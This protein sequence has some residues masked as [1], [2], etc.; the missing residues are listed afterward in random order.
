MIISQ[1]GEGKM[2]MEHNNPPNKKEERKL[3][4]PFWCILLI[5]ILVSL[6]SISGTNTIQK[7]LNNTEVN[8]RIYCENKATGVLCDN[9]VKCNI[10]ISHYPNGSIL[11]ANVSAT[12]KTNGVWN[13]SFGN[14]TTIGIY[15]I[16]GTCI[17]MGLKDSG[18]TNFEVVSAL[19]TSSTSGLAA[20]LSLLAVPGIMVFFGINFRKRHLPLA[21][22]FS[23]AAFWFILLG[24]NTASGIAGNQTN[25]SGI[26]PNI[27]TLYIMFIWIM[28][29]FAGYFIGYFIYVFGKGLTKQ[30]KDEFEIE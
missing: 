4:C 16:A 2:K 11:A 15:D 3:F 23:I 24:I 29:A 10:T 25:A 21:L 19:D 5:G 22:L 17:G 6:P 14:L 28:I 1:Y 30:E 9:S 8:Y 13:Y 20:L 27:H 26:L 12:Y 18:I 7:F